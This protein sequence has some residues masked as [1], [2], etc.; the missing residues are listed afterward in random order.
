MVGW[1]ECEVEE[2]KGGRE[3]P[4]KRQMFGCLHSFMRRHSRSKYL[5]TS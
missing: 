1:W 2:E 4:M 3:R 5:E